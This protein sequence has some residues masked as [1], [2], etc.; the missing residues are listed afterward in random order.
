M[1]NNKKEDGRR[2]INWFPRH[3]VPDELS[4]LSLYEVVIY[5]VL[6]CGGLY[7]YKAWNRVPIIEK[8]VYFERL[9][10]QYDDASYASIDY[11][12]SNSSV[13]KDSIA[14]IG[15]AF[16][17]YP[18]TRSISRPSAV[19]SLANAFCKL[20]PN[21]GKD[22]KG[23]VIFFGI[24]GKSVYSDW[25]DI[26]MKKRV[27]IVKYDTII[28]DDSFYFANR[29]VNSQPVK[30]LAET[31]C[32]A[33]CSGMVELLDHDLMTPKFM[34]LRDISQS[35]FIIRVHSHSIDSISLQVHFKGA[36]EITPMGAIIPDI[37]SGDKV[38]YIFKPIYE[39]AVDGTH[40][41]VNK[42]RMDRFTKG[43]PIG[44][45]TIK[46]HVKFKD[47]ENSQSRR[48][49]LIST[50]LSALITI[51]LAFVIIFIYRVGRRLINNNYEKD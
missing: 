42:E 50:I 8:D 37:V 41:S 43:D 6:F 38:K 21:A 48:V 12:I 11:Y 30:S 34:S 25:E 9:E 47:M 7:L 35:Y 51:F 49:F 40:I 24:E 23:P 3:V 15:Y 29:Y 45:T 13:F 28:G 16:S 32:S 27:P 4:V 19:D 26:P 36:T 17:T 46:F 14:H 44:Y 22:F 39:K 20:R 31:F 1:K 2:I 18:S 33:P 5:A 10:S